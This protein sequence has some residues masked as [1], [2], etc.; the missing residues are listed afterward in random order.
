[1]PP[2]MVAEALTLPAKGA[3]NGRA[4]TLV[5]A[6]SAAV[7]RRR[8]AEITHAYWRLAEAIAVYHYCFD[9]N[10]MIL[11]F[12]AHPQDAAMLETAKASAAAA[13]HTAEAAAID[14]QADLAE[15]VGLTPGTPLP[16][17]SDAPHVGPYRTQYERLSSIQGFP[18]RLRLI[19]RTLPLC[20]RAIDVRANA[21]H[22][23]EDALEGAI[24]AYGRA[25]LDFPAVLSAMG[26][27]GTQRRAWIAVV[28]RYNHDIAD[29]VLS[30]AHPG[31]YGAALVGMLIRSGKSEQAPPNTSA[32][33]TPVPD[34][35]PTADFGVRPAS[36]TETAPAS[37]PAAAGPG[38]P[39][40]A[41]P[42]PK[43]KSEASPANSEPA[44]LPE[45]A[46]AAAAVPLNR[47]TRR[48]A[49][50]PAKGAAPS[51]ALYPALGDMAP[52]V[53]AKELSDSLHREK[54]S[55]DDA[56][57]LT[58]L[59]NCLSGAPVT[60]RGKVIDAYWAVCQKAAQYQVDREMA[61]L[62]QEL[63]PLAL[64]HRLAPSG[65]LDMLQLRA[66]KL[67]C[68]SDALSAR[69]EMLVA[70]FE[71][72]ALAGRPLDSAWLLPSTPPHAGPYSLKLD[73]QPAAFG[74]EWPV[75][76]LAGAIPAL[77]KSLQ[78]RATA[79]VS[80][81]AARAA[82]MASFRS[83]QSPIDR[84]LLCTRQQADQTLALLDAVNEYNQSI[85]SYAL[86][87]LPANVPAN[88]IVQTLVI[89]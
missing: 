62:L 77:D 9:E 45:D 85:A 81:D 8:Q 16:L 39:T 22:A 29:Y 58:S 60:S 89:R 83:G 13:L 55:T 10:A 14:A 46:D 33:L 68:E 32:E 44:R 67:A 11:Q 28:C 84:V 70:Q 3:I 50:D 35:L 30:I 88:L 61:D 23:A 17:P 47:T 12:R 69:V 76:R 71:L 27:L 26:Q 78:E 25:A 86:A 75:R 38:Q 57:Q 41:P 53:R 36:H 80:A 82:A 59:E 21:V 48:M 24:D 64:E 34:S 1:M 42:R 54:G 6:L 52:A 2:E 49:I 40:L 31:T 37:P 20:C 4:L 18:A 66:E 73:A 79:V 43:S 63:E 74:R 65:A 51:A 7:D 5:D 56:S 19:D 87:V 72:T 15:A